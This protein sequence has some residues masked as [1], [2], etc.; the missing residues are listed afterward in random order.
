[1]GNNKSTVSGR[2]IF[3]VGIGSFIIAII[4]TLFSEIFAS[5]LNNLIL[6]FVFL[7]IIITINILADLVG[8]AV[9]AAS[10]APFNAKAAKRVKGAPQGLLLIK[11]ADRVANIANDIIGDITTTVSGALG[12]S[13]V[14]QIMRVGPRFDQ[15]WLNVLLT[16]LISVLIVTGK[17]AGKKVSLSHPDEIIFFVGTV[18]AKIESVTGYNFFQKQK[19]P[20]NKQKVGKQ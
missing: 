11:N 18:L 14:V 17:A 10:H 4:F 8:T 15:F 2:Y 20:K 5:K 13:I 1:M 19:V 3:L 9:T 16:A 12:I 7:I 6:S